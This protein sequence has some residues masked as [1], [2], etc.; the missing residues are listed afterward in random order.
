M[1]LA[2]WHPR[3]AMPLVVKIRRMDGPQS[4]PVDVEDVLPS[5]RSPRN[6]KVPPE[7]GIEAR[8]SATGMGLARAISP[9]NGQARPAGN[10]NWDANKYM[11]HLRY[12]D[13]V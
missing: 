4:S 8:G 1:P 2:L 9:R 10:I 7:V 12:C 13:L 11:A 3:L 5:P 6:G